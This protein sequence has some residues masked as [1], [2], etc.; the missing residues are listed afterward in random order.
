MSESFND[1]KGSV[2]GGG[3][4]RPQIKPEDEFFHSIYIAGSTRKNYKDE[5]EEGGKLQIRGF[6][7]NLTEV[8]MIILHTHQ[9]LLKKNDKNKVE[10]F[11]FREGEWPWK[12]TT[13]KIC[14]KNGTERAANDFC[15]NCKTELIVAG[16]LV[17]PGERNLEKRL[18]KDSEGRIVYGFIRG[19]GAKYNNVGTYLDELS[20]L[21]YPPLFQPATDE[22]KKF[23]KLYSNNKRHLTKITV[24]SQNTR[25]GD[26]MVFQLNKS[27][28]FL[29][30]S[31][32]FKLLKM[33]KETQK[34]FKEKFDWS[35]NMSG[36]AAV[37][38]GSNFSE[39]Q[40]FDDN[41][42]EDSIPEFEPVNNTNSSE[43]ENK[44]VTDDFVF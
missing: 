12:S 10:C 2:Y 7:I 42:D 29:E 4:S 17:N 20:K 39:D 40:I 35:K 5:V 11:S 31:D 18:I 32:V 36:S 41:N 9:V 27:K 6:N 43:K 33:A 22:T 25:Y 37:G 28:E 16:V 21:E 1:Y 38:V 24:G 26:K 30:N 13:G 19:K 34:E 3:I 14:C 23:E 8:Y 15:K 44:F